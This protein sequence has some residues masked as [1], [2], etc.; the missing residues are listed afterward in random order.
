MKISTQLFGGV[1]VMVLLSCQN[2]RPYAGHTGAARIPAYGKPHMSDLEAFYFLRAIDRSNEE[3]ASIE[4]TFRIDNYDLDAYEPQMMES[5]THNE[6]DGTLHTVDPSLSVMLK[7]V[8][9]QPDKKCVK[10]KLL[11]HTYQRN[12][13]IHIPLSDYFQQTT[14]HDQ[15]GQVYMPTR[16]Q[17]GRFRYKEGLKAVLPVG[18]VV[19]CTLTFEDV[20]PKV[21]LIRYFKLGLGSK[22]VKQKHLAYNG[23]FQ[24][25]DLPVKWH[26]GVSN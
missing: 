21:N 6:L 1:L 18:R 20:S 25:S 11:L 12:K 8:E 19:E 2:I 14:M 13:F 16:A 10:L 4:E 22:H 26:R 17:I 3:R 5:S 23:S 7:S 9:G 24:A 15:D